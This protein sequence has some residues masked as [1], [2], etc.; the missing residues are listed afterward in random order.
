[1]AVNITVHGNPLNYNLCEYEKPIFY[2]E[3]YKKNEIERRRKL[4]LLQVSYLIIILYN[5]F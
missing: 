3:D 2:N 4:R 5:T 1:M